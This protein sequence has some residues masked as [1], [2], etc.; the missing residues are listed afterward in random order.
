MG[1]VDTSESNRFVYVYLPWESRDDKVFHIADFVCN[2]RYVFF[3]A[4]LLISDNAKEI[5]K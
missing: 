2:M 1:N 4:K 5:S 3:P